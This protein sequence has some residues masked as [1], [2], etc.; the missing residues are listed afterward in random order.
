M[1]KNLAT[2]LKIFFL[3]FFFLIQIFLM[4]GF[5]QAVPIGE[6]TDI[7]GSVD[8]TMVGKDARPAKLGHGVNVG[9]IVQTK[10][11]SMAEITLVDSN[12]IRLS[13]ASRVKISE[14][15]VKKDQ[16]KEIFNLFR[17]T[18]QSIVKT[19]HT[20]IFG[21]GKKNIY[22]VH[23][24]TAV[25]GVRG[26][27][28]KTFYKNG[29]SGAIF[30]KGNGYCYNINLPDILKN[31]NAGQGMLILDP[32]Q[33]PVIKPATDPLFQK[34]MDGSGLM[35]LGQDVSKGDIKITDTR[36]E[37]IK[38][39]M[40]EIPGEDAP[41]DESIE[42]VNIDQLINPKSEYIVDAEG[43][44]AKTVKGS[45]LI[46]QGDV[47]LKQEP[48]RFA[49]VPSGESPE[50]M[51]KE[52][53]IAIYILTGEAERDEAKISNMLVDY[54]L[55]NMREKMGIDATEAEKDERGESVV[56]HRQ[57]IFIFNTGWEPTETEKS[58]EA[59]SHLGYIKL[60]SIFSAYGTPKS[61]DK[62]DSAT[63]TT[64]DMFSFEWF[65]PDDDIAIDEFGDIPPIFRYKV[66][67]GETRWERRK[68]Q[69]RLL[70][71]P[72]LFKDIRPDLFKDVIPDDPGV[73]KTFSMPGL[74]FWSGGRTWNRDTIIIK[75]DPRSIQ[76]KENIIFIDQEDIL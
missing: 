60:E 3:L 68:K 19:A 10:R 56:P 33:P 32:T 16:T 63:E 25:V 2:S 61:G 13:S 44:K 57:P 53:A 4:A 29:V 15:L 48:N 69:E 28:F 55:K 37:S 24:P 52:V 17:G 38:T 8:I 46:Q 27:E 71:R 14:Y 39:T 22:E 20:R 66:H 35:K 40:I 36:G 54:H 65:S 7:K 21:L 72:D 45:D 1:K 41:K 42:L 59:E 9:D 49:V 5:A 43:H 23:T 75:D 26:S 67:F 11:K 70:S 18:V 12:I 47:Q 64:T 51:G 50:E 74:D 34:Y 62:K 73:D 58:K 31:I 30:D 6:F 76:Q